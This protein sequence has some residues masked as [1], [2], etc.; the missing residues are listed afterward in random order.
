MAEIKHDGLT[1]T[2]WFKLDVDGP[3]VRSGQY[4]V[5]NTLIVERGEPYG[6]VVQTFDAKTGK[7]SRF[8]DYGFYGD[9]KSNDNNGVAR[10]W[11]GVLRP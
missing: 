5:A 9:R 2:P 6:W 4:E 1:R 10:A 3:P 8:K 7:W 11:R